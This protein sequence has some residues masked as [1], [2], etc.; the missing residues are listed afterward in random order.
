MSLPTYRLAF[1]P[2]DLPTAETSMTTLRVTEGDIVQICTDRHIA[3]CS[4]N[5]NDLLNLK[6]SV[7]V[8]RSLEEEHMDYSFSSSFFTLSVNHEFFPADK[9]RLPG[10]STARRSLAM[11]AVWELNN[12]GVFFSERL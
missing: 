5:A 12:G 3:F 2:A 7:G 1:S 10:A 6:T 9:L 11:G 4:G 8:V